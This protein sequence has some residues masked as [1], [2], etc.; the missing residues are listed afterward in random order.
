M[1]KDRV[2]LQEGRIRPAAVADAGALAAVHVAAWRETYR[3]L[4]PDAV[5][6]NLSPE[7]RAIEWADRLGRGDTEMVLV[8]EDEAGAIVGFGACGPQRP[9]GLPYGGEFYALHI[10]RQAQRRGF[11]RRLMRAMSARLAE[12]GHGTATLWVIRE[13]LAARQFYATLGGRRIADAAA[14]R[15]ESRTG[16]RLNQVA[17]AWNKLPLTSDR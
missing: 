10:L 15:V 5:L 1:V 3:G 4:L 2:A 17:Y 13:N 11:G 9:H 14:E 8:A 12:V 16:Y 7:R 6:N